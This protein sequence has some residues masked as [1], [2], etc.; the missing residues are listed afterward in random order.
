MSLVIEDLSAGYGETH[1]LRG[2][3]LTVDPGELVALLGRNGA[4][5]T[6]LAN[7]VMGLMVAWGGIVRV[8]GEEV[9][10]LP[11]HLRARRG[12]ALSP[13]GRRVFGS[14]TVEET[15]TLAGRNGRGWKPERVYERFPRLGERRGTRAR[16]LSGGEQSFL[17]LARALA[18]GPSVLVLDEPSEG[19]SP[20]A[21]DVLG[22]VLGALRTEGI[23]IL[24]VEQN[25]PFAL[26]LADRVSVMERGTLVD[27]IDG[28]RGR[29]EPA[30]LTG[31]LA[32][33]AAG[34]AP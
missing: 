22:E 13:Q 2:V 10:A 1:I 4:G 14:L 8:G 30:L 19:L 24:L 26:G 15:L 33:A 20:M 25:L 16:N 34:V 28:D 9:Q 11:S 18:T 6:T 7:T 32:V 12:L 17:T 23:A 27:S 29:A 21:L 31:H 5:K 3:D